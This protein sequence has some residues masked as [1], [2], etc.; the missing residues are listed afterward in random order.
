MTDFSLSSEFLDTF[1]VYFNSVSEVDSDLA[2]RLGSSS[3]SLDFQIEVSFHVFGLRLKICQVR[4]VSRDFVG[5]IVLTHELDVFSVDGRMIFENFHH[6]LLHTIVSLS[7][8][9]PNNGVPYDE[10]VRYTGS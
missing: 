1:L 2:A 9:K 8:R 5:I 7:H 4:F 3:C 10:R 6:E